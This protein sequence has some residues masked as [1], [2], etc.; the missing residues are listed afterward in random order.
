MIHGT[1][2]YLNYYPDSTSNQCLRCD[3]SCVE[4]SASGTNGCSSCLAGRFLQLPP[5]PSIC[6]ASCYLG[7]YADSTLHQCL[8][9]DGT[10][11]ECNT[12]GPN[13]CTSCP[14][15]SFL[16][17]PPGPSTCGA[18]CYLGYYSD[19]T[20]NQC[21]RCDASCVECSASGKNGCSSCWAGRFLLLIPGPSSCG[22]SCNLGY[23]PDSTSHQCL[24]CDGT[25]EGCNT[26][27]PSS[28]TSFPGG[29]FLLMPPGPS[30]CEVSLI[31]VI[32]MIQLHINA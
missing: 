5:G 9:C 23:Y 21:L 12:L 7:Y 20:S 26:L 4:C 16:L 22:T 2:C 15:G 6:G 17:L 19:S 13:S 14:A 11:E 10:C 18:S 31:L 32:I 24:A 3:A 25:C 27:G 8:A 29:S 30:F 28:C 1:S